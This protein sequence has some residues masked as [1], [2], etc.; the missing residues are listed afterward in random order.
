[1]EVQAGVK[2]WDILIRMLEGNAYS[3]RK[4]EVELQELRYRMKRTAKGN[5]QERILKMLFLEEDRLHRQVKAIFELRTALEKAK[6]FYEDSEQ[7]A[8]SSMEMVR[9]SFPEKFQTVEL[10]GWAG[11]PVT[12]GEERE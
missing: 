11:I 8:V 9:K 4:K 6:R 5:A 12:L 2:K 1:M 7:N 10:D 3:L